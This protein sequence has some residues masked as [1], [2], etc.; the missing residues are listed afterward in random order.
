MTG[1]DDGSARSNDK[2]LWVFH[3][4]HMSSASTRSVRRVQRLD[5]SS[6]VTN[7]DAAIETMKCA[8]LYETPW[9]EDN[10]SENP[11]LYKELL[12]KK[13]E[14]LIRLAWIVP[15]SR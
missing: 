7:I 15:K 10:K 5:W 2:S 3:V 8:V 14:R 9:D 13:A 4:V 12:E 1:P 11:K 6:I